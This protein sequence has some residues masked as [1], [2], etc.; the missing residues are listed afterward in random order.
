MVQKKTTTAKTKKNDKKNDKLV[1]YPQYSVFHKMSD[2]AKELYNE[3]ATNKYGF[4]FCGKYRW[5]KKDLREIEIVMSDCKFTHD[6]TIPNLGVYKAELDDIVIVR[7]HEKRLQFTTAVKISRFDKTENGIIET[8][9]APIYNTTWGDTIYEII[10]GI[11]GG[12][13]DAISSVSHDDL[14]Q[15]PESEQGDQL[16]LDEYEKLINP[17][18]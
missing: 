6:I 8:V 10:D 18:K 13:S 3:L 2:K 7:D 16:D 5:T 14:R 15:V 12:M 1:R 17:T 11:V 4:K 9:K